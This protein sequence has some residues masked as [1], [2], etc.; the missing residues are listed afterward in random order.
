M[1]PTPKNPTSADAKPK[2]RPRGRALTRN[3]YS[4][5]WNCRI[6]ADMRKDALDAARSAGMDQ[7]EM[8][9]L[10][11][12]W[13]LDIFQAAGARV[14]SDIERRVILSHIAVVATK[15][16]ELEKLAGPLVS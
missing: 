4:E 16:Q 8:A 7:S 6:S 3:I 1:K 14:P 9:R 11:L 12:Q 10:A 15:A 13:F 5:A 2:G